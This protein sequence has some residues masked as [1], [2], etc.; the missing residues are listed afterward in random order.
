VL[1]PRP[2]QVGMSTCDLVTQPT[3]VP[4]LI[5]R[6]SEVEERVQVSARPS[7]HRH[8]DQNYCFAKEQVVV[9]MT[10]R[11]PSWFSSLMI[12]PCAFAAVVAAVAVSV[13]VQVWQTGQ[14][15]FAHS[16]QAMGMRPLHA[17]PHCVHVRRPPLP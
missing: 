8:Y 12:R 5:P 6:L 3:F 16:F 2:G 1:L 7:F 14:D 10:L 11:S 15:Q 17:S 4:V 13:Q 9:R